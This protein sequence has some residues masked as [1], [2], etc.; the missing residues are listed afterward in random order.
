MIV[1]LVGVFIFFNFLIVMIDLVEIWNGF[2]VFLVVV[3]VVVC[4]ICVNLVINFFI[5]GGWNREYKRMFCIIFVCLW[6]FV[7]RL[8]LVL[9]I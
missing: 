9:R 2:I 6:N 7:K 3:S 5:Y 1:V 4:L 8:F